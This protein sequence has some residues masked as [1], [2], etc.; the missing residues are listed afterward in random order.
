MAIHDRSLG[1]ANDRPPRRRSHKQPVGQSPPSDQIAKLCEPASSRAQ[2][3]GLQGRFSL[4][5]VGQMARE[6]FEERPMDT[7]RQIRNA[8]S[9]AR[10]LRRRR[11]QV[12]R[13][14]CP[15]GLADRPDD[16]TDRAMKSP[17]A[18]PSSSRTRRRCKDRPTTQQLVK[19]AEYYI[20]KLEE[21]PPGSGLAAQRA[22]LPQA[23]PQ[24]VRQ[25]FKTETIAF[26]KSRCEIAIVTPF[27]NRDRCFDSRARW[28]WQQS[29]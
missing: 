22:P 26:R 20:D 27:Y 9:G 17:R 14:I 16:P 10:R 21:R 2:H 19:A 7:S 3:V 4:S 24:Y 25:K 29:D 13:R 28:P 6:H 11:A 1:P 23:T 15:G 8:A 5:R 12:I 18:S